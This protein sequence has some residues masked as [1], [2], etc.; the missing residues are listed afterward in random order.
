MIILSSVHTVMIKGKCQS[1]Q[2][3]PC[4]RVLDEKFKK[5]LLS[6]FLNQRIVEVP[7]P[8]VGQNL[9]TGFVVVLRVNLSTDN[10]ISL[11]E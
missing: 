7:A 4:V 3:F 10:I 6:R 11:I 9:A 2:K 8:G 5:V 1:C